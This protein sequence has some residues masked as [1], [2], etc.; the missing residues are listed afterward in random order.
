MQCEFCHG[1]G[2]IIMLSGY[3]R[4]Y[5]EEDSDAKRFVPFMRFKCIGL[6]PLDF[7]FG[8]GWIGNTV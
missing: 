6:Q 4:P 7:V 3:G 1:K 8:N 2:N 5:T